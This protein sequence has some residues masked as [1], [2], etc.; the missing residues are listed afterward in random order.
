MR[1]RTITIKLGGPLKSIKKKIEID[2]YVIIGFQLYC[3]DIH[4]HALNQ[5]VYYFDFIH[6]RSFHTTTYNKSLRL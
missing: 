6:V 5:I 1:P 2:F 4:D 3:K